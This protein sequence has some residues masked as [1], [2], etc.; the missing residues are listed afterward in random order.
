MA[1][2]TE[3]LLL[4]VDGGGS[5]TD[6]VVTDRSGSVLHRGGDQPS[7][8]LSPAAEQLPASL[9][10]AIDGSDLAAS[11]VRA[12]VAGMAGAGRPMACRRLEVAFERQFPRARS[13]VVPDTDLVLAAIHPRCH[14]YAII[15]G[16]GAV[17]IGRSPGHQ[18]WT[19]DGRGFL[20]GD[21]GGGFWIGREAL[22]RALAALDGRGEPTELVGALRSALRLEHLQDCVHLASGGTVEIGRIA[23][24]SKV[25]DLCASAGDRVSRALLD[26]AADALASSLTAVC[27]RVPVWDGA[28]LVFAGGVL[29]GSS[30]VRGRL[31][32]MIRTLGPFVDPPIVVNEPVFGAINLA[33]QFLLRPS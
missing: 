18:A 22:A 23:E 16:T 4:G 2:A 33:R 25:V 12:I 27:E 28:R 11:D 13:R 14:G 21:V 3:E 24:L 26:T 20:F 7:N 9:A 19:S 10:A 32:E 29:R 15:A 6:F 1:P 17:A 30:H 8:A 31:E 5:G